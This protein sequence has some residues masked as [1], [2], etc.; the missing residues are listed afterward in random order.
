MLHTYCG[1]WDDQKE[2]KKA[3]NIMRNIHHPSTL[4]T[5]V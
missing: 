2:Q 5:L 1:K 4:Q 3:L